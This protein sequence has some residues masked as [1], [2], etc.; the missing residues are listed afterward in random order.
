MR[1]YIKNTDIV[2]ILRP[3][4]SCF[5]VAALLFGFLGA[6]VDGS[7]ESGHSSDL[8]RI[9]TLDCDKFPDTGDL[10]PF[11]PQALIS[12]ACTTPPDVRH[13][14]TSVQPVLAIYSPPQR[15]PTFI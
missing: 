13:Y 5:L 10:E 2:A 9:A 8:Q 6:G 14:I 11:L 7:F 3:F 4:F 15:P 12:S 1:A